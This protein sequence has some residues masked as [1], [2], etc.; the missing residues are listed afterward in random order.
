[1]HKIVVSRDLGPHVMPVLQES[2]DLFLV[3][4]PDNVKDRQAWL[5]EHIPGAHG[6][7]CMLSDKV[8]GPNLKVVSTM[9]VGY[10][11]VHLPT[12]AKNNIRLG[13]TPDIL[14][15]A[16]A[17]LA[18]MLALMATRNAKECMSVWP[19]SPWTP[20][21]FC[22]PQLSTIPHETSPGKTSPS[23]TVG[24]FGFGRIAQAT[25]ARL[26]PFGI[27]KFI[28][29]GNSASTPSP[30]TLERDAKLASS[31]GLPP[32]AI[33]RVPLETLA[34]ESDV[35]FVLAP[36][37]AGT[38]HAINSSF[39]ARM[40]PTSVLV[41]PSRGTIVDSDALAA[42][43]RENKIWGAALDVVEGEPQITADHPLVRE[44]KCVVL[45]HIGSATTE[46]RIGIGRLA[47]Y[48]V[49]GGVLGEEMP[50]ELELDSRA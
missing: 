1:M 40:K 20:F 49:I 37:G 16:V 28:Y 15:N 8:T 50:S 14:T 21:G 17:D 19:N 42:A 36:G 5:L 35:L 6:L 41:N 13:Y 10:E 2:K 46:T 9:S 24:F 7:L 44:P 3:V 29:T 22:G 18:I 33:S 11:H 38:Y 12:L 25:L 47:A 31:V 30:A 43:L 26:V 45:P 48:N 39:L 23:K 32:D 34:A 27:R 4:C